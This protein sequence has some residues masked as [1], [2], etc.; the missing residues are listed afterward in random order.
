MSNTYPP[1]LPLPLLHTSTY[2]SSVPSPT[3][4]APSPPLLLTFPSLPPSLHSLPSFPPSTTSTNPSPSP[5]THPPSHISSPSSSC[6]TPSYPNPPTM[7]HITHHIH[8]QIRIYTHCSLFRHILQSSYYFMVHG[9]RFT[10]PVL[11]P[12]IVWCCS[13]YG[14]SSTSVGFRCSVLL[15]GFFLVGVVR[16]GGLCSSESEI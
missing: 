8:A 3:I 15:W 4:T 13:V 11:S 7:Y 9:S 1:R 6:S 2:S 12:S 10:V 5:F 16:E 14:S